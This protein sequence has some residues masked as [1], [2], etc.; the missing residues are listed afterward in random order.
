MDK[1]PY[2]L[3]IYRTAPAEPSSDDSERALRGHRALQK[4]A[5]GRGDLAAVAKLAE[6]D[7]AK[8]VRRRGGSH[9]VTDGPYMDTKEW[10]VGFYVLDCV[11]EAE[12]LARA[13]AICPIDGH[14]IEVR[15][16]TWRWRA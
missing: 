7:L 9:D 8:T 3:L 5:S 2:A 4:E 15:P 6:L 13:K 1:S 16:V 11:D 10:L 14:A 12:A